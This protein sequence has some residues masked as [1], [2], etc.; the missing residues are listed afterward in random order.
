MSVSTR[1]SSSAVDT[2]QLGFDLKNLD[3]VFWPEQGLTKGDLLAYLNAA[4][5]SL[6]PALRDR[7]LTLKRSPEGV[8]RFVFFQKNTP[9]HAPAWLRTVTL[10]AETARRDV[11][12]PLCNSKRALLWMGNQ[13]AVE[14]HPWLS[15]VD[16]LDRP[17]LLVFDVDP[18]EGRFTDAID[19][20]LLVRDVLER[21]GLG[22]AAKTS[23]AKGVH[24][25]VPL[26]RRH[27]YA[28][29]RNASERI[30]AV[31][32]QEAPDLVTTSFRIAERGGRVYLDTGRNAAGAHV[33]SPFSPR[34]RPNATVSFPVPWT[35]LS[36]VRPEAFT[37]RSVLP[38][39]ER[40]NRWRE[41]LPPPQRLPLALLKPL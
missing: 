22:A 11:A 21:F 15:R 25:F 30:A 2:R 37:I 18:Q 41:L 40:G 6:V 32:Q 8:H 27:A 17:D 1:L 31:V 36:M 34:A 29:V 35:D 4:A 12:Y 14:F 20:A 9:D 16:L 23:G 5:E 10:R 38:I 33:V 13:A 28:E 39:L 26:V 7:P 19:V 24:V 3:K